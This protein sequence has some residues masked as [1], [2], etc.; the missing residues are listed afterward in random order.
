MLTM[1]SGT[2]C[3]PV[4]YLRRFPLYDHEKPFQYLIPIPPDSKDQRTTNVEFETRGQTFTDIRHRLGNFD[5]DSNGFEVKSV[6][7]SLQAA[8]A[9]DQDVIR[10]RYLPEVEKILKDNVAG[11]FDRVVFFD[12]RVRERAA[13]CT[14]QT[15]LFLLITEIMSLG[16]RR[17]CARRSNEDEDER[18]SWMPTACRPR[19]HRYVPTAPASKI[20]SPN[21]HRSDH[22][23]RA[24]VG[25]VQSLADDDSNFLLRGRAR[26][27]KSAAV[28]TSCS[29]K[30][31]HTNAAVKRVAPA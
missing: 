22:A 24:I 31:P 18:P 26:V 23:P 28:L 20:Y 9:T 17:S 30:E 11:G 5:L 21:T 6:P 16:A 3:A 2:I 12:W 15:R 25:R 10:G 14:S 13:S 4:K 8:E 27:I 29:H 1:A 7:T 19:P